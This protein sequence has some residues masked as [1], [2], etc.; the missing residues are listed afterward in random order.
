DLTGR[1]RGVHGL[2]RSPDDLAGGARDELVAQ[3][4]RRLRGP[5]C[6]LGVDHDLQ[7][8]TLVAEV[9]EHEAAVIAAGGDPAGHVHRP[10][11]VLDAH[12]A[13]ALVSPLAHWLRVSSTS[14]GLTWLS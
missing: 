9:D 11:H 10:A 7:E 4:V 5:G 6:V 3:R 12:G 13:P 1:H 2:R 14:P 8:A